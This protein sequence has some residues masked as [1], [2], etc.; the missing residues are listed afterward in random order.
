MPHRSERHPTLTQGDTFMRTH[1]QHLAAVLAV[2]ALAACGAGSALAEDWNGGGSEAVG[3]STSAPL[4]HSTVSSTEVYNGAM[5]AAR[6][7]GTEATGQSTSAPAM[8]SQVSNDEV[9]AGAVAAAHPSGTEA[10]GQSTAMPM[11]STH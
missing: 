6:P 2:G 1:T 7:A 8:A 3:Q 5:A 9:Y 10:V 11:P 4:V